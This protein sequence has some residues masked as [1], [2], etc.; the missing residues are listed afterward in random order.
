MKVVLL[1][2][3]SPAGPGHSALTAAGA[4]VE[5]RELPADPEI[6]ALDEAVDALAGRR[7]VVAGGT[8]Q[9]ALVLRR[10]MRRGVL[11]SAETAVLPSE[12]VP[13]LAEHGITPETAA[14]V[15]VA[16]ACRTVGVLKDDSGGVMVDHAELRP[17]R[18][19]RV[20]TRAYV[21][22]EPVCD[23]EI[24]SLH[25]SRA[26]AGQLRV[27]ADRGPLRRAHEVTGRA[28]QLACDEAAISSDG[29]H[30]E[31][32][33]RKR[34]WWNEPELWRLACPF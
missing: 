21:D 29:A 19:S 9:L 28:L 2:L 26:G 13:F 1:T 23:G 24:R 20:W 3:G 15:A 8:P 10:L 16:A 14:E 7:L 5:A 6:T 32:P 31:Q 17:W 27:V 34:V 25:V 18:G 12:Q 11:G 22:D 30:R 33:R 4:V